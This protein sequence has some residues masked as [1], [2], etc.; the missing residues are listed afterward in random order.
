VSE[1]T[2]A[3]TVAPVAPRTRARLA[4]RVL[5]MVD[6]PS[7][8]LLG[9]VDPARG[10]VVVTGSRAH[11]MA[12]RLHL[13][14]PHLPVL[15]EP[16]SGRQHLATADQPFLLQTGGA[17]GPADAL[18]SPTLAEVL[19]EQRAAHPTLVITPSGQVDVGDSAALKAVVRGANEVTDDD[20]ATLVVVSNAWLTAAWVRQLCAVLRDSE[21]P[22]LLGLI[23]SKGDPLA[24]KGAVEGYRRVLGEVPDVV[25][26]RTD[27]SGLGALA[28]G[29]LATA[30]GQRPSLRRYSKVGSTGFA[31]NAADRSPH[32]LLP[33]L[34]HFSTAQRMRAEWFASAAPLTCA[35]PC[36]RGRALDRFDA[37]DEAVAAAHMHNTLALRELAD[38]CLDTP[39]AARPRWWRERLQD[40]VVAHTALSTA[41]SREVKPLEFVRRWLDSM[42]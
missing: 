9:A 22:I 41:I 24:R 7:T 3:P 27:L 28:H 39:V 36:C 33:E 13:S 35:R 6:A 5:T 10:G 15:I 2:P 42:H 29:A 1:P 40:A 8:G 31:S 4:D 25:A 38:E 37:S 19:A 11:T 32:V 17:Q 18:W 20:V 16:A 23:D 30:V 34:L 14:H 12:A 26:W 21:H